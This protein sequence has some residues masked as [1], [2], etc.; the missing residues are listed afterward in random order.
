MQ[1]EIG[2]SELRAAIYSDRFL[3][4]NSLLSLLTDPQ[5]LLKILSFKLIH[6]FIPDKVV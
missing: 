1:C 2:I 3:L 5:K 6:A 4:M